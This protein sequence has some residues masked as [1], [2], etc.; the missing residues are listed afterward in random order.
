MVTWLRAAGMHG[1]ATQLLRLPTIWHA[2]AGHFKKYSTH[3][4]LVPHCL[5]HT[6][7]DRAQISPP[8]WPRSVALQP[9]ADAAPQAD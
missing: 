3:L 1:Q 4:Q 5:L 6:T 9:C 2:H 7:A 8:V